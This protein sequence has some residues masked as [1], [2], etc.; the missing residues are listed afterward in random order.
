[1]KYLF[2]LIVLLITA[3]NTGCFSQVQTNVQYPYYDMMPPDSVRFYRCQFPKD[4]KDS[5]LPIIIPT[6][7]LYATFGQPDLIRSGESSD[8]CY[9][10]YGNAERNHELVYLR[11]YNND[12]VVPRARDKSK[13]ELVDFQVDSNYSFTFN[14]YTLNSL[15]TL[16]DVRTMFPL[17]YETAY[18]DWLKAYRY[19]ITKEPPFT[20]MLRAFPDGPGRG[21]REK[22]SLNPYWLLRFADGKLATVIYRDGT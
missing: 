16:E 17:S 21:T 1:M 14:S 4:C 18:R 8:W 22:G 20:M 3:A 10:N 7:T 6:E 15:T 13:F 2:L 11:Y 12:N 5:S 19:V 9:Y